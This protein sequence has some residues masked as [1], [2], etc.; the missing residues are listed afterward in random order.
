MRRSSLTAIDHQSLAGDVGRAGGQEQHRLG[1][2][3]GLGE[4]LQQ[5]RF[6]GLLHPLGRPLAGPGAF[7]QARRDGVDAHLRR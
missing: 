3:G 4:A 1:N 2:I 6:A 7:H 5:R